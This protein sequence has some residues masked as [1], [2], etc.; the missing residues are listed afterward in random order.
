MSDC[1][2]IGLSKVPVRFCETLFS[3]AFG[4]TSE[5]EFSDN[6]LLFEDIL[7]RFGVGIG[8]GD[9]RGGC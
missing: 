1:P 9:R 3:S 2:G 7:K 6:L 5:G 8:L 4:G